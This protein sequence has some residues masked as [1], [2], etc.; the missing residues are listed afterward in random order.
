ME[1]KRIFYPIETTKRELEGVFLVAAKLASAGHKVFIGPKYELDYCLKKYKPEIYIGTRAD[2]T[3]YGLLKT[4]HKSGCR[5]V[6]VDT[7]GGIMIEEQYKTRHYAPGLAETDLFFA[8]GE[9]GASIIKKMDVMDPG[10]IKVSGAPWFDMSEVKPLYQD[11]VAK[12]SAQFPHSFILFNSRLSFPNHKSKNIAGSYR[13]QAPEEFA[14]YARQYANL[15]E[16]LKK[17]ATDFP[18]ETFVIRA[19]PSE[20]PAHYYEFF[21]GMSNV[22][23]NDSYSSRAWVLASKLVLHNSCTTGLEAAMMGM[24][25]VAY[26]EVK[27]DDYDKLLPNIASM[28]AYTY[29]QLVQKVEYYI[30]HPAEPYRLND[31]QISAI[32]EFFYNVDVSGSDIITKEVSGLKTNQ[33]IYKT[34]AAYRKTKF[35]MDII[36]KYPFLTHLL[37]PGLKRNVLAGKKYFKGKFQSLESGQLQMLKERLQDA[38]PGIAKFNIQKCTDLE[39][40]YC[41]EAR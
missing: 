22:V 14:Y 8:W 24:P 26:Q 37:P 18:N 33:F 12:I 28:N 40:S 39:H 38:N 20:D 13:A 29:E 2:E 32:K 4:L 9:K 5:I 25:V 30:K 41:F 21:K 17:L 16:T 11:V 10:H 3:N 23:I 7:E 27:S 35:K 34:D 15:N 36:Y 19:H 31:T 1:P 6:I